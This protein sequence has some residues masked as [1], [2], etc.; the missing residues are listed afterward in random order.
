M[1]AGI[2]PADLAGHERQG[3]QAAGIVGA[4]CMLRDAHAPED[5]R[6]LGRGISPR[7]L[8]DTRRLDPADRRD[9]L[10]AVFEHG[11]FQGFKTMRV[12]VN[13][14]LIVQLFGNDGVHHR[15]Q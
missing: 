9:R 6:G 15:V 12:R 5:D 10:R 14:S 8:P 1:Q 7:D 4:V 3:D 11:L 13:K 2:G